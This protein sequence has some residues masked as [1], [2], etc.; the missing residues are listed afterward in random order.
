MNFCQYIPDISVC[1][2]S[3]CI[4]LSSLVVSIVQKGENS[5]NFYPVRRLAGVEDLRRTGIPGS[6]SLAASITV[7]GAVASSLLPPSES[8][9]ALSILSI[10][11]DAS[12]LSSV[13]SLV[14]SAL[15]S[16]WSLSP[17][18]SLNYI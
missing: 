4:V 5:S 3:G 14:L 11:P 17:V 15:L 8:A 12:L 9:S 13:P 7:S 18:S 10:S 1:T 6:S 2:L 16:F